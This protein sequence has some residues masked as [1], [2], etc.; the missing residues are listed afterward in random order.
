QTAITQGERVGDHTGRKNVVNGQGPALESFRIQVR[1]ATCRHGH[2]RQ[3]FARGAVL[4]H[5]TGRRQRITVDGH[6]ETI[7][8]LLPLGLGHGNQPTAGAALVGAVADQR[9][10]AQALLEGKGGFHDVHFKACTTDVG[11][12]DK[13]RLQT[14]ILTYRQGG[15]RMRRTGGKHG[16]DVTDFQACIG[17]RPQRGSAKVFSGTEARH[18]SD[19]ETADP[20]NGDLAPQTFRHSHSPSTGTNTTAGASSTKVIFALTGA[21]IGSVSTPSTVDIMRTPS[22]RSTSATL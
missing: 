3:H 1:P 17:Y 14:Q 13:G 4:M 15:E 7:R 8:L 19:V 2:F 22:S 16:I 5:V 21:P 10:V 11:P 9:C 18:I 12:A 6:A 20:C